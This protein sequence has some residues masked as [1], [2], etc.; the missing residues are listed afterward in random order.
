ML[1]VCGAAGLGT[2]SNGLPLEAKLYSIFNFNACNFLSHFE[3]CNLATNE[4]EVNQWLV[5]AFTMNY[6]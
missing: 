1:R 5:Y 2:S 6:N 4:K 3:L